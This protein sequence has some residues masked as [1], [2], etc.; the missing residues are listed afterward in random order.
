MGR[1]GA[2]GLRS[3]ESRAVIPW[4]GQGIDNVPD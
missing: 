2:A 4:G 1:G 3:G